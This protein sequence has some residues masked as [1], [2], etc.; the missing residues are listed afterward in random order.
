MRSCLSVVRSTG[1]GRRSTWKHES[2]GAPGPVPESGRVPCLRRFQTGRWPLLHREVR[3]STSTAQGTRWETGP[4]LTCGQT[5]STARW[6]LS[7]EPM[8]QR[9]AN[10]ALGVNEHEIVRRNFTYVSCAGF[11]TFR[12]WSSALRQLVMVAPPSRKAVI[13]LQHTSY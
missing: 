8:E 10:V 7:D 2:P 9:V 11:W 13:Q 4:V 12:V 6:V 5:Q 1:A 3:E